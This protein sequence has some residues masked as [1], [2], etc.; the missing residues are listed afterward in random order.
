MKDTGAPHAST[1]VQVDHHRHVPITACATRQQ[2][3]A[4]V[5]QIGAEMIIVPPVHQVGSALTARSSFKIQTTALQGL[6]VMVTL[7]HLVEM[8]T[9]FWE[10]VNIICYCPRCLKFKLEWSPAFH[11][12]RASTL[13]Q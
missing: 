8:A 9:D 4:H 13:L 7:L 6:M 5:I 2:G 1:T 12:V 11:Q 3:Y 10:M